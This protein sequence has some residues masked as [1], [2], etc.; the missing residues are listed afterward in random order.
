MA[1]VQIGSRIVLRSQTVS[2]LRS[3]RS[4]HRRR[5]R[6]RPVLLWMTGCGRSDRCPVQTGCRRRLSDGD[7]HDRLAG[8]AG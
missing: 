1:C 3:A 8:P 6:H 7:D 5:Y 2:G 4:R